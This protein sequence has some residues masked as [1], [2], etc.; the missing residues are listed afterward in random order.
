MLVVGSLLFL[1][2]AYLII[3]FPRLPLSTLALVLFSFAC[4]TLFNEY[5][6]NRR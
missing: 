1:G 6:D 4:V 2:N 3:P 5:T